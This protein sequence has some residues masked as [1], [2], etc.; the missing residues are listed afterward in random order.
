MSVPLMQNDIENNS[1]EI[2]ESLKLVNSPHMT[3]ESSE[4]NKFE[5]IMKDNVLKPKLG[6]LNSHSSAAI[7][8]EYM[9][10]I[11]EKI[12]EKLRMNNVK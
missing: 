4:A 7:V 9:S 5:P 1:S 8:T 6:T 11:K 12:S 10:G 2:D 3:Q